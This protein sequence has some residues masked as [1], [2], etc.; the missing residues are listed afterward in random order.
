MVVSVNIHEAKARL[1][2]LIAMVQNRNERVVVCRYGQAVA[3]IVPFKKARRTDVYEELKNI[4][5]K[6][7][8]T[9]PTEEDWEDA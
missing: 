6:G 3:E 8:L 2:E 1:S 4:T 5:I 9:E 7:D